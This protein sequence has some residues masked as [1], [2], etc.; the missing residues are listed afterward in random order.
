MGRERLGRRG[1]KKKLEAAVVFWAQG[2]TAEKNDHS[3]ALEDAE[4]MGLP[5]E[6]IAELEGL[7]RQ[8]EGDECFDLWDVNEPALRWFLALSTQW[9]YSP[10]GEALGLDYH[11]AETVSRMLGLDA[12]ALFGDLRLAER[13]LLKHWRETRPRPRRRRRPR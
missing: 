2:A 11:A 10:M 5:P 6:A 1:A 3:Q 9:R 12:T 8:E 7:E 13:T 4:L